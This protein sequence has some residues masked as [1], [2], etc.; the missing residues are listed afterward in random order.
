MIK[1]SFTYQ[2]LGFL[3]LLCWIPLFEGCTML[4][5]PPVHDQT[6]LG[7]GIVLGTQGYREIQRDLATPDIYAESLK[8]QVTKIEGAAYLIK[9][10][11]GSFRRIPVDQNT[12]ID[13]P[14]H[15]GDWIEAYLDDRG[16][17]I[18]IRNIDIQFRPESNG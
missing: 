5:P 18:F 16:R 15:I 10:S 8:G 1:P 6:T 11:T 9:D 7:K 2:P 12:S 4:D 14:A 3:I 13:R 17:A